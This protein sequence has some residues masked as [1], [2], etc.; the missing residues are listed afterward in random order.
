MLNQLLSVA[1]EMKLSRLTPSI[2]SRT[3][4]AALAHAKYAAA[5]GETIPRFE[6]L[7]VCRWDARDIGFGQE[8][9]RHQAVGTP[10]AARSI[11]SSALAP[12]RLGG[13]SM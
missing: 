11:V 6:I 12:G 7:A 9:K 1:S 8:V 5:V 13:R 4:A 3:P 2:S 10:L